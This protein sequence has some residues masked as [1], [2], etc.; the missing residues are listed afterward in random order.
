MTLYLHVLLTQG[1]E[2]IYTYSFINLQNKLNQVTP[3]CF[4]LIH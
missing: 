2:I 1:N 4:F 3:I